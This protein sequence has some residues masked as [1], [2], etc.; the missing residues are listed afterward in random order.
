MAM[1]NTRAEFVASLDDSQRR[2]FLTHVAKP[3]HQLQDKLRQ[4]LRELGKVTALNQDALTVLALDRP[5][6]RRVLV[7]G[8]T[9]YRYTTVPGSGRIKVSFRDGPEIAMWEAGRD[10]PWVLPLHGFKWFLASGQAEE[11][12]RQL[13]M[14]DRRRRSGSKS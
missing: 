3:H 11:L 6:R 10:D 8:S 1:I 12:H 4:M 5:P 14:V 7:V 2:Y 13:L 9:Q